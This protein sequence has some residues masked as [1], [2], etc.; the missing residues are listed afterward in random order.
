MG[1]R[2]IFE[3]KGAFSRFASVV[4]RRLMSREWVTYADVM[5]AACGNEWRDA[6]ISNTERY[7]ELKKAFPAVCSAIREKMGEESIET[8][9]NKR[10]RRFRYVGSDNDP[11]SDLRNAHTIGNLKRYW[12]FCQDSAGFFPMSWLDYFFSQSQ[13]LLEIKKRRGRSEQALVSSADSHLRN[14]EILPRLYE[15]IVGRQVLDIRYK[16][17]EEDVQRL[18]FHPHLLKEYNRRW[19][20]FGHAEGR[21]PEWGYNLPLDR[22]EEVRQMEGKTYEDAPKGYYANHFEGLVGVT[23]VEGSQVRD[24]RVRAHSL[25]IFMLMDTKRLHKTQEPVVP[26]GMHED[27]TYGEFSLRVEVNN[28]LIGRLLQLGSELEVVAPEDVRRQM[29]E[30]VNRMA[31]L[32]A[33]KAE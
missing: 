21:R 18:T 24:I 16:P 20:L 12:Q 29:K 2:N 26:Y 27:G 28:E 3:G 32:Y 22:I 30:V 7:G 11:L 6:G 14:I 8:E 5:D 13:D 4:Y 17:Y 1:R 33:D 15:A 25:Y 9:G 31:K 19:F 23:H 10:D